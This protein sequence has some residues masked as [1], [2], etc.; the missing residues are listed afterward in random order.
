MIKIDNNQKTWVRGYLH[1]AKMLLKAIE[2]EI[3]RDMQSSEY[4]HEKT[5]SI[6]AAC[7]AIESRLF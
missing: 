2:N 3:D 1:G 7:E 4:I 5:Q 6:R